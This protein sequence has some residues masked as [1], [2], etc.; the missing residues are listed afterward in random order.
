MARRDLLHFN[1]VPS[2]IK[3]MDKFG[4]DKIECVGEYEHLRFKSREGKRKVIVFEKLH[5]KNHLVIRDV[6]VPIV[7]TF[8]HQ[9]YNQR[10]RKE[11]TA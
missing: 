7:L 11:I 10:N 3:W 1:H 6:D 5:S 4:Y 2:F 9:Q 8:L